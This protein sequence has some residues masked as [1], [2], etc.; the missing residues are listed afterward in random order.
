MQLQ[1]KQYIADTAMGTGGTLAVGSWFA[2]VLGWLDSHHEAVL[3]VCGICGLCISI[4]GA[5]LGY[6]SFKLNHKIKLA[7][8]ERLNR[9]NG[10][11][12]QT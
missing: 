4:F 2:S 1:T 7:E 8:L 5:Y 6:K 10:R 12:K 11:D 9:I 3:A